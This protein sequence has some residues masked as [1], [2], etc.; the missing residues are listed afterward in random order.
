[1]KSILKS[2]PV[3][4]V[5]LRPCIRRR[6][7][8]LS[9]DGKKYKVRFIILIISKEAALKAEWHVCD[10]TNSFLFEY[11][12][13]WFYVH[14]CFLFSP[15]LHILFR[16]HL[17]VRFHYSCSTLH[18]VIFLY[19]QSHIEQQK[20]RIH[21]ELSSFINVVFGASESVQL[22]V[23]LCFLTKALKWC[24]SDSYQCEKDLICKDK[25]QQQKGN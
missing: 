18:Y 15:F 14:A 6:D 19:Q 11:G 9:S 17:R 22:H 7:G 20:D 23:L 12:K 24:L 16:K 21:N 8:E 10:V 4:R 25:F 13:F 5:F 2:P 3:C 1:M